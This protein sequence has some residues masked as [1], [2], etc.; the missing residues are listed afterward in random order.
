MILGIDLILMRHALFSALF[1]DL[2]SCSKC[3]TFCT[4]HQ[5]ENSRKPDCMMV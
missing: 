5:I 1:A 2:N 4:I 3:E